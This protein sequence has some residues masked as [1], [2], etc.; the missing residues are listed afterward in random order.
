[1]AFRDDQTV[2]M[3]DEVLC[4]VLDGEAVLL[5]LESGTYFGLDPVG[6]RLWQL[7]AEG[8]TLGAI[9]ACMLDEFDV[10]AAVLRCDLQAL[11]DRLLASGLIA[12]S[13]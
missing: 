10:E 1:M 4:Q 3:S 7:A 5:D 11:L 8:K 13:D 2:A 9:H 6:T 12:L